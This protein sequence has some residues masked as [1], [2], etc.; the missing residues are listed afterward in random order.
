MLILSAL[1]VF[2]NTA[3]SRL[4][5]VSGSLKRTHAQGALFFAGYV[6]PLNIAASLVSDLSTASLELGNDR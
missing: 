4:I 6:V 1:A 5:T 3:A 2:D